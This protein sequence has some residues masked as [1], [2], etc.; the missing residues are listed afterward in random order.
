GQRG[1]PGGLGGAGRF[2]GGAGGF[3]GGAPPQGAPMGGA[4][5]PAGNGGVGGLL[6]GSTPSAALT[7]ALLEDASSYTWIAATVGANSASGY[8]LATGKPVMALGGFNGTDPYPT[9]AAFESLVQAHKG[10]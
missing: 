9:L 2:P 7:T 1:G 3:P 8:Q 4:G 6:N 10:H 5:G